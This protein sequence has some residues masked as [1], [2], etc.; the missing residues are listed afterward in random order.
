MFLSDVPGERIGWSN[1]EGD[2]QAGRLYV[3]GSCCLFACLDADTGRTVWSRSLSEEFGMLSTYGGRTNTP[4]VFEDLVII[5]GV[6]TGWGETALPAHRVLALDKNDGRLVWI[7]STRPLPEDTTY[8]TPLVT[9]FNGQAAIVFGAGDGSVYAMQPRTGKVIWSYQLSRRGVNLSPIV[10]DETVY[11]GHSEENIV[12]TSM[13]AMAAI[14]GRQTGDVTKSGELWRMED[15]TVGKSSPLIIDGRLYVVDDAAGLHVLDAR[16]GQQMGTTM[17]LGTSMRGSLLWA[18]G[19]IYA[20][21]AGGVFHTLQIQEDGVKSLF[22]TRLPGGEQCGGSPI[23]SHGR[24]YLPTTGA[25]YCLGTENQ[26]S[27]AIDVADAARLPLKQASKPASAEPSAGSATDVADAARL[28]LKQAS[29]PASAEPS[30]GSATDVADAARLPLKQVTKPASAEPSAGSATDVADAARLPLKQVTKP[31]SAEPSAGSATDVADAARLPLKQV[32]KPASAEPSAGSATDVA[33]AARL[34]LKQV[35]KPAS[36]EPS[37]GSATDV[38]D[39]ARLPLKQVT[40][41]ASAEPSAGSAT[42]VADAARLPLKQVTKSASAE[43]S[44]GSATD[45]ADAAR[46]P[47]KQVTK[48]ASAEPS[49]GSAT[50]VAEAARLPTDGNTN[51]DAAEPSAGSATDVAS[52]QLVPAEALLQP[53]QSLQ[54]EVRAYNAHGQRQPHPANVIQFAV[55]GDGAIDTDGK[56]QSPTG[57][58]HTAAT[59]TARIGDISTQA[60]VRVVPPLPWRFDFSDGQLPITWIGARYRH[61]PRTVDGEPLIV[62]I[63]TIPKGTRSQS[64]MGMADLHDYTVQADLKAAGT[65]DKLPDM[66]IIAQRYTLDIMGESQQLQIRTWP[67]QLRMAQTTAFA[68][69]PGV[70]YRVKLCASVED[71]KAML[72]GKVWPREETEPQEWTIT[73]SDEVPNVMGS[74]GLYGNATNAEIFI[75]NIV[76]TPN[77]P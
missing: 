14:D 2:P 73:A 59:V 52:I 28:P 71:G 19:K 56:F 16:N 38:A 47:L 44:A 68:W 43:P 22:R 67:P 50:D 10:A 27:A 7:S 76:V 61:E 31:A 23:V 62:K 18:D 48:P 41:S 66:G 21:T 39:A 75:D 29:K 70:W 24:L 46:L 74:P 20:C 3:L 36:A 51:A 42:D 60:R 32:T 53:G 4:V 6:T 17:K 54:F 49:A 1:L 72:R 37:A 77:A 35:S 11:I 26:Q 5:S 58:E 8:S 64:W 57:G 69:R 33:D 9:A 30:A 45:V 40:K 65:P 15:L 34:P 13:G 12:G 63:S 25:L 55:A